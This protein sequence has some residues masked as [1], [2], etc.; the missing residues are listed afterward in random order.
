MGFSARVISAHRMIHWI[1]RRSGGKRY[2]GWKIQTA[3]LRNGGQL[4]A[5]T[6]KRYL[7]ATDW[8]AVERTDW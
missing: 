1:A 2:D 4:R 3:P 5:P 6:N 7:K 8:D